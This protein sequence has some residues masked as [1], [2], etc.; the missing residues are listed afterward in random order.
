MRALKL[1]QRRIGRS[2][3]CKL[4]KNEPTDLSASGLV[5]TA[6]QQNYFLQGEMVL[7]VLN[8]MEPR[9]GKSQVILIAAWMK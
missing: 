5:S 1:T 3:N 7:L 8:T 2:L 6:T 4:Y 9:A